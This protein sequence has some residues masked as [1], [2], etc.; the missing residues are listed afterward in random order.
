MGVQQGNLILGVCQTRFNWCTVT[1][2]M[3]VHVHSH[4]SGMHLP[5]VLGYHISAS[6]KDKKKQRANLCS[7]RRADDIS[8]IHDTFL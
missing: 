1:S 8:K 2:S 4:M 7:G 5:L 6:L 3:C